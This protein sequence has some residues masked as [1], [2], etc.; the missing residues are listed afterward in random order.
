MVIMFW[1][2]GRMIIK[3]DSTVLASKILSITKHPLYSCIHFLNGWPAC[4]LQQSSEVYVAVFLMLSRCTVHLYLQTQQFSCFVV[5]CS[6]ERILIQGFDYCCCVVYA[7][8]SIFV[9]PL[10][11]LQSASYWKSRGWRSILMRF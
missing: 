2:E 9:V 1:L 7:W 11:A 4:F 6:I 8:S 10:W 3:G 5:L